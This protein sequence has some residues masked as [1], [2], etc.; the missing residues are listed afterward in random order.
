MLKI[1]EF[2]RLVGV[3]V[4]ML[5]HY[6]QVGLLEPVHVDPL[7]GYRSYSAAQLDRANRLVALKDLG[8]TLDQ[9]GH[10]LADGASD[11]KVL[12]LLQRRRDELVAHVR[13]DANRLAQVQAKIRLIAK[14][15]PMPTFEETTLPELQLSAK[16]VSVTDM[17]SFETEMGPL[18]DTVNDIVAAA[19]LT[20]AGPGV[21]LYAPDGDTVIATAGE[22]LG[23]APAP[24]GLAD[25]TEPAVQRALTTQYV[26]PDLTG[27]QAA[28]QELVA[29]IERRGLR[30][31]G[32][33]REVYLATPFDDESSDWVVDLQQPVA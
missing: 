3:S 8:F 33:C 10:L 28:W 31:I 14:E 18:F 7:T 5:R 6:D 27:I 17:A 30:S 22:P 1:G 9:V 15:N 26:A 23:G 32:T 4:R 16:S 20:P 13:E 21:A 2:A 29:E 24:A 25:L 19:G 11:A 12:G